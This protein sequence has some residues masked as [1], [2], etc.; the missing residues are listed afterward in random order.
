[1]LLELKVSNFA[2]I[3]HLHV[4][5]KTGLNILSGE[6]GS[7]KSVLLKSL[8]LLM[9]Q[10]S[11]ADQI[12]SG[13][14]FAQVEGAF[15]LSGRPDLQKKL[16]EGGFQIDDNQ[17]IVKRVILEDKSRIYINNSISTLHFLREMVSPL[18]EVTGS[19][20][21]DAPT[22][23]PLL[24]MTGQFENRNLVSKS[25]QLDLLDLYCGSGEK[26]KIYSEKFETWKKFT[27]E[28]EEI[29]I[30]SA[31]GNQRL[32]FLYF[33]KKEIVDLDLNPGEE[34]SL[35]EKIKRLKTFSKRTQGLQDLEVAL[36]TEESNLFRLLGFLETKTQELCQLDSSLD[37][38]WQ[39][40]K[41][42]RARIEDSYFRIKKKMGEGLEDGEL[43]ETFEHRL[44]QIRKI[45]KKFGSSMDQIL[46]SLLQIETE[47]SAIEN[48]QQ[49][50]LELE[51][52]CVTLEK[53]LKTLGHKLHQVRQQGAELLQNS[54]NAELKDLNMKGVSFH[55]QATLLSLLSPT[56]QTDIE[57][58]SQTSPKDP[59]KAL[60]KFASGG[61]L[62]RILL[63]LKNVMGSQNQPRTYLFDEVDT[64]VSGPTA[65]KVGKKLK[66]IAKGQQVLC[67]THLPQVAAFGDHHFLI[68]K[69]SSKRGL[70]MEIKHLTK[71]ERIRELARLIS[72]EKITATSLAH[73][74]QLLQI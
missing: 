70:E 62:S 39:E 1:M 33:Q 27:R 18:I 17:M 29:E 7:G 38:E 55:I 31:Q 69:Q 23:A 15:D 65:E 9:G 66:S 72:G 53:E 5:F 60:G 64:G 10:K 20:G 47:I 54:V 21:S 36:E 8:A 40:L 32:D 48:R 11:S 51:K 67:V 52:I 34:E 46:S 30:Q 73:A 3:D 49:R 45:Q 37:V 16:K 63:S 71:P 25:Y 4:R 6:T 26:R 68:E 13:C 61:E 24:E 14:E 50:K 57:F 12:R 56:G 19:T 43:L 44:S 74:E 59:P 42:S 35:L 22:G 2:I 58:Q 28:I 41:N